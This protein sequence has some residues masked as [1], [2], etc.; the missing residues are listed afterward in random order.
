MTPASSLHRR[1]SIYLVLVLLC[2]VRLPPGP[3]S[4]AQ[5]APHATG[6][7]YPLY[8][9][10]SV[11]GTVCQPLPAQGYAILS[12]DP[13]GP[14]MPVDAHPDHNLA[15]RGYEPTAE[16]R[17]LVEYPQQPDPL[18]PQFAGLFAEPR[19][20]RFGG[21]YRV[22]DWDWGQMRRGPLITNPPVTALGLETTAG[23]ILHVPDSGYT[24]GSGCEVLVIYATN[25]RITLKYTREDNV[26]YGYTLHVDHICVD[27]TLLAVYQACHNAG[28]AFLPALRPHQP[29]GRAR[30]SEVVI[31]IVD[32]GTFLDARSHADW[33]KDY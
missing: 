28:R 33:W 19:L 27:P 10:I 20:P 18:A 6:G 22:H 25:D 21:T 4:H 2:A 31:A 3:S 5:A 30:G 26:V 11:Q 12:A 13:P 7:S 24:I 17:G 29:F 16:Y 14:T 9:P 1:V 8:L 23:E 32:T 15:V